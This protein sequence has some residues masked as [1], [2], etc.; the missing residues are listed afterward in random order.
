[1]LEKRNQMSMCHTGNVRVN[2]ALTPAR[3]AFESSDL[4]EW[5]GKQNQVWC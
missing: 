2:K 3:Y 5:V 4:W 1:M